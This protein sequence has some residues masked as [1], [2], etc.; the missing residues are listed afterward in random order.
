MTRQLAWIA[1]AF[2]LAVS[3]LSCKADTADV[4]NSFYPSQ[5][6]NSA[7]SKGRT[8]QRDSAFVVLEQAPDGTPLTIVAAY[9]NGIQGMFRV[10]KNSGGTFSV[11]FENSDFDGTNPQLE[12]VDL[13]GDGSKEIAA[14]STSFTGIQDIYLYKWSGSS[15]TSLLPDGEELLN[16]SLVD[17]YHDGTLQLVAVTNPRST[18]A[19]PGDSSF[20]V[21]RFVNGTFQKDRTLLLL[22]SFVRSSAA[23]AT[24]TRTFAL[25]STISGPLQLLVF[26]GANGGADRVSAAHILVNGLEVVGPSQLNQNVSSISVALTNLSSSNTLQVQ[27]DSKPGGTLWVAIENSAAAPTA[28]R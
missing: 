21:F 10:L 8:A 9:T 28:S 4:V 3:T 16:A 26:N 14:Y 24:T 7:S 6:E 27:L 15:L 5:L 2:S 20:N 22:Q 1:I 19:T 12:L 13:A 11:A 25:P 18:P 17:L 23:P